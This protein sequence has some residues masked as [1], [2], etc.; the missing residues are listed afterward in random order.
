MVKYT[1]MDYSE[2]TCFTFSYCNV[3]IPKAPPSFVERPESLTRPR[4]G[5]ARFVCQAEGIPVPKISW[6]KN[7]KKIH[8]NGR[9]KMYNR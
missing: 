5:T 8:S 4:A 9:I 1:F 3:L 7:G 2:M 6:L